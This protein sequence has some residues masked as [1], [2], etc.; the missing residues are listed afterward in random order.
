L[1]LFAE[2]R[3]RIG[4]LDAHR[5]LPQSGVSTT[6]THGRSFMLV[7]LR[8]ESLFVRSFPPLV[9]T[10]E[11]ARYDVALDLLHA[12]QSHPL[13]L[14][15]VDL[16]LS[17]SDHFVAAEVAHKSDA[18][19]RRPLADCAPCVAAAACVVYVCSRVRARAD[20]ADRFQFLFPG[21]E[22]ERHTWFAAA[23]DVDEFALGFDRRHQWRRKRL[24]AIWRGSPNGLF[25]KPDEWN[26]TM[27][28]GNPRARLVDFASRHPDL[29]DAR[30][31]QMP[32]EEAVWARAIGAFDLAAPIPQEAFATFRVI[33]DVDGGGWSARLARLMTYNSVVLRQETEH[34]TIYT[35]ELRPLDDGEW[36]NENLADGT[37]DE[38]LA[39]WLT[40]R[41]RAPHGVV[42]FRDDMSDLLP[43]IT[44]I[45]AMAPAHLTRLVD[46]ARALVRTRL[47]F[48]AVLGTVRASLREYAALQPRLREIAPDEEAYSACGSADS[49]SECRRPRRPTSSVCRWIGKR[50]VLNL[51]QTAVGEETVFTHLNLTLRSFLIQEHQRLLRKPKRAP[52]MPW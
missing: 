24:A 2:L 4:S 1:L 34:D 31:T 25:F 16:V 3:R 13:G 41:G 10:W 38:L 6:H 39:R 50:C 9:D 37:D 45:N 29:L 42:W 51:A 21:Y 46:A 7:S 11:L 14:P 49:E 40:P 36:R 19:D 26:R 32:A 47:T 35:D 30:F 20:A 23:R 52:T 33:L 22:F 27:P 28:L 15:S 44:R 48:D 43:L 8:N 12:A 5:H 18:C 17:A